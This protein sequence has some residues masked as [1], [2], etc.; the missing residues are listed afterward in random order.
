[1]PELVQT[2]SASD[3]MMDVPELSEMINNEPKPTADGR[4]LRLPRTTSA[5]PPSLHPQ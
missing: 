3:K 4:P 5:R 1:M 2:V